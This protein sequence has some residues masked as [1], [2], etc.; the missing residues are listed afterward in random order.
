[1]DE[2]TTKQLKVFLFDKI[3]QR[4]HDGESIQD[5]WDLLAYC[6]GWTS[7]FEQKKKEQDAVVVS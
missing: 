7:E 3:M 6:D 2:E 1:M 5:E 4:Y